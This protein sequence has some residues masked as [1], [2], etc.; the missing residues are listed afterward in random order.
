MLRRFKK[1]QENALKIYFYGHHLVN[2]LWKNFQ[3]FLEYPSVSYSIMENSYLVDRPL[4]EKKILFS[5]RTKWQLMIAFPD[6]L[7][8]FKFFLD[9][10]QG[11]L[12]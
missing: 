9:L 1:C 4:V 12:S 7:C 8:L 11:F 10:M 6:T 2:N 3:L 5:I